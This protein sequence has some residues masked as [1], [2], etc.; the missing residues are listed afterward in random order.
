MWISTT[1]QV[2]TPSGPKC[3]GFMDETVVLSKHF[4]LDESTE[5]YAEVLADYHGSLEVFSLNGD[6]RILKVSPDSAQYGSLT[7][8]VPAGQYRLVL[9]LSDG[10]PYAYASAIVASLIDL[11]RHQVIVNTNADNWF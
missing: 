5:V 8:I 4:N 6:E 10:G 1:P 2:A 9:T 11:G 3:E 7:T